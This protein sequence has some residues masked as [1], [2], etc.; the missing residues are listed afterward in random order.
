MSHRLIFV[1]SVQ[2]ENVL[3]LCMM[4]GLLTGARRRRSSAQSGWGRGNSSYACSFS[5][6]RCT[7]NTHAHTHWQ[8]FQVREWYYL[9][10]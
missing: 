2:K 9:P 4:C 7:H 5:V 3:C 10:A 1:D 8:R 6:R